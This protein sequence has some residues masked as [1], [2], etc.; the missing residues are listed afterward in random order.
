MSPEEE[1]K[2]RLRA[3]QK[4]QADLI[5]KMREPTRRLGGTPHRPA[6]SRAPI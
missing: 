2:E 6:P 5:A 3:T 1:L 4:Y